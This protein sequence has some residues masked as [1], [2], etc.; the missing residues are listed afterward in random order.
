MERHSHISR[1]SLL[2]LALL[3]SLAASAQSISEETARKKAEAF[4]QK[5]TGMAQATKMRRAAA[6]QPLAPSSV[7]FAPATASDGNQPIYLFNCDGGGYVIVSGD[8]RTFDILGYSLLGEIDPASMPDNM[9]AWLSTYCTAIA[10]LSEHATAPLSSTRAKQAI[11]PS[12]VTTWNQSDPYNRTVPYY[13]YT[14]DNG[15]IRSEPAVTGCTATAMAQVMYYYRYPEA[16]KTKLSAYDG[17]FD[18]SLGKTTVTATYSVPSVAPGTPIDWD[19]MLPSY[20]RGVSYTS[21]QAEAVSRLMQYAGTAFKMQYGPSSAAY[22]SD[23]LAAMLTAFGYHDAYI[24]YD[25]S[26]DT[27]AEWTDRVYDEL[28]AAGV[29]AISGQTPSGS[30]GHMFVLDGVQDDDFFHVNWGWGGYLDGYFKLSL[31]DPGTHQGAGGST[32]GY[33]SQQAIIAG[34]GFEGKGATTMEKAFEAASMTLGEEGARY[35]ANSLG[36]YEIDNFELVFGNYHFNEVSAHPGLGI[37][38]PSGNLVASREIGSDILSVRLLYYYTFTSSR[39]TL[40]SLAD[41]TYIVKPICSTSTGVKKDW[42]PMYRSD[43]TARYLTVK[44]GVATISATAPTAIE[45]LPAS[46]AAA[47]DTW[48]TLDGRTLPEKPTSPG[49]YLKGREKILIGR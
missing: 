4:M 3:L 13:T 49:V 30:S 41:G 45:S 10:N 44:N 36:G 8:E 23:V 1:G 48:R 40:S 2:S 6:V 20:E 34:L 31:M 24:F 11:S 43:K 7:Q 35:T 29:V 14:A 28:A 17:S 46:P 26:C 22:D 15:A 9:R 38:D 27:Y 33:S 12:T 32:E 18:L 16:V 21:T 42:R 25:F 47:D 37:Y 19:N 39:I 5:Q